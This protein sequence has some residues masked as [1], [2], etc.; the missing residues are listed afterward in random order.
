[1]QLEIKPFVGT[2]S[3][4]QVTS[5]GGTSIERRINKT[6]PKASR[7]DLKQR[8]R[9][10]SCSSKGN[11][12]SLERSQGNKV[13]HQIPFGTSQDLKGRQLHRPTSPCTRQVHMIFGT[14]VGI[15]VSKE[16]NARPFAPQNVFKEGNGLQYRPVTSSQCYRRRSDPPLGTTQ[17]LMAV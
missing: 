11:I 8:Q 14:S 4:S 12:H 5:I 7:C 3:G 10:L 9:K 17:C 2:G 13:R 15:T 1:M 6:L 16:S